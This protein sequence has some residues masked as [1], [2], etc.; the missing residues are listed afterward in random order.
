[1]T[2]SSGIHSPNR[3]R[4]LLYIGNALT[5]CIRPTNVSHSLE[6]GLVVMQRAASYRWAF[7]ADSA[8]HPIKKAS[9]CHTTS[10]TGSSCR[11]LRVRRINTVYKK[12]VL[13]CRNA[14]SGGS[15]RSS[16]FDSFGI[17]LNIMH[18]CSEFIKH[19]ETNPHITMSRA[20]RHTPVVGTATAHALFAVGVFGR[21]VHFSPT[22]GAVHFLA[23]G[24]KLRARPVAVRSSTQPVTLPLFAY[25]AYPVSKRVF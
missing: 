5:V 22:L 14:F 21:V 13:A 15:W 6:Y 2:L 18:P 9:R 11:S 3:K 24:N 19:P 17:V 8:V 7:M 23:S 1:M 4:P 20:A 25:V 10:S 12:A 16:F